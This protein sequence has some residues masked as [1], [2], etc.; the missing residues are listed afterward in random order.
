[1]VVWVAGA[2]R[3]LGLALTKVFALAGHT[4]YAGLR[5]P[6]TSDKFWT[7]M[8]GLANVRVMTMDMTDEAQIAKVAAAIRERDG[9]L[10]VLIN[11]AAVFSGQNKEIDQVDFDEFN[12]AMAVNLVGPM[13]TVKHAL[14]L[15][16]AAKQPLI[17]NISSEAGSITGRPGLPYSYSLSKAS[18]NMF[19]RILHG[20]YGAQGLRVYAVHPGR[21]MTDMGKPHFTLDP[22]DTARGLLDIVEGREKPEANY[23]FIDYMGHEMQI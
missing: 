8:S 18:L 21:M 1:M 12:R 20:R 15:L 16:L 13:M 23:Q 11:N 9:T 4:V 10:D 3:G 14:P 17:L 19:T 2:S 6:E 5:S 7:A 22:E